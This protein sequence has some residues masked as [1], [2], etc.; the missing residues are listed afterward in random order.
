MEIKGEYYSFDSLI[1]SVVR[2]LKYSPEIINELYADNVDYNSLIY[3]F[4]DAVDYAAQRKKAA[5]PEE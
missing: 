2:H 4:N 3:W 1:K 5:N